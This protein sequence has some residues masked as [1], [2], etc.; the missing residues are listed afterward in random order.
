MAEGSR[1]RQL[2]R[3]RGMDQATLAG[4][5]GR[6]QGWL[7]KVESGK[8][9]LTH[10]ADIEHLADALQVHPDEIT[11]RPHRS[12]G[13]K[14]TR[15]VDVMVPAIRRAI[16]DTLPDARL[17]PVLRLRAQVEA[18]VGAMWR[19]GAMAEMASVV[20][21]LLS[22]VRLAALNGAG[23]E[24]HRTA[25]E[26]LAVTSSTTFP[27]LKHTGHVDL[28][29][30]TERMCAAAAAELDD[31]VWNAYAA[32]R[33]S[34]ALIPLKLPDRALA[35]AQEAVDLAEPVAGRS[36]DA[37]RVYGFAH[38]VSAVWAAQ[39]L[40]GDVA[41]DH[42]RE[43]EAVAATVEDG[44]FFDLYFGPTNTAIHRTQV[45][46]TLGR[47]GELPTLA[48]TVNEDELT[49]AVQRCYLHTNVALGLAQ[50]RGKADDAVRELRQAEEI[51][52]SRLRNRPA[53]VPGLVMNLL[54]KPM[55]PASLRELR[56][57][58]YRIGLGS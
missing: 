54:S 21:G 36:V 10:S 9:R 22:A 18:A 17:V 50:V 30:A 1:L 58:A 2:R 44:D 25:V 45:A 52:P 8:A 23:E 5:A 37:R 33:R 15:D 46:A 48:A 6:T 27:L 49:S 51:A 13:V 32:I 57:L 14:P 47:G 26:L 35:I 12:T 43:A 53:I 7:S 3:W 16:V 24:D 40:R 20:P 41:E 56:G 29:L 19:T 34:H 4:L 31:P 11:G 42:L 38:L 55:R 28:A 39:S